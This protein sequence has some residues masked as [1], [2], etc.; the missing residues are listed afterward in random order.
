MSTFALE[1]KLEHT[2]MTQYTANETRTMVKTFKALTVHELYEIL[3]V[4]SAVF[5]V[6]QQIVY[7]DMD[8]ID[9]TATHVALWRNG[10]IVAYARVFKDEEPGA[11]HI[12]RVLTMQRNK[13]YGLQVMKE[14]IKVAKAL[15]ARQ[16]KIEAQSYAVGFYEKVGF[17]VCSDKFLLDGILHN[18]MRLQL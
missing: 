1:L 12:G 17:Q 11:W 7:Q 13:N 16:V 3:K 18:R 15:G 10:R 4:R 5:V 9:F 6:E 2:F 14:A 8:N